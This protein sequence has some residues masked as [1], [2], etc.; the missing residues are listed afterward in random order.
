MNRIL[1]APCFDLC[2]DLTLKDRLSKLYPIKHYEYIKW[3]YLIRYDYVSL[4]KLYFCAACNNSY[5]RQASYAATL[6]SRI[7]LILL[8]LKTL[9][10][11]ISLVRRKGRPIFF[12]RQ[13][14]QPDASVECH[15]FQPCLKYVWL[16]HSFKAFM[17]IKFN[18]APHQVLSCNQMPQTNHAGVCSSGYSLLHLSS[19]IT[20]EISQQSLHEHMI[21][22]KQCL[23][24]RHMSWRRGQQNPH[25]SCVWPYRCDCGKG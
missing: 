19:F 22:F 3:Q 10:A 25:S 15:H 17:P 6:G 11:L 1:T 5:L 8:L 9:S 20:L 21:S 13:T 4:Y 23:F 12:A 7:L 24:C 18:E 16:T 2:L 14:G